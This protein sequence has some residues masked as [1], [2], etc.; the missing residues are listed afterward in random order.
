MQIFWRAVGGA[1]ETW[2]EHY[3]AGQ[4]LPDS[5]CESLPGFVT[6]PFIKKILRVAVRERNVI[7]R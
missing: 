7:W 5:G 3:R 2:Y 4:N 1:H 6:V